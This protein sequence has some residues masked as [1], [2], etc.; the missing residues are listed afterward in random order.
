MITIQRMLSL[1][2]DTIIGLR[3]ELWF[4]KSFEQHKKELEKCLEL[5]DQRA[6]FVAYDSKANLAGVAECALRTDYV[7][8]C[9]TSPVVFL[10]GIFVKPESRRQGVARKL[11]D[12]CAEW[13]H[14]LGAQE[15][16]S[17]VDIENEESI[18][19]H[20]SLGFEEV[21]RVVCF[22]RSC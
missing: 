16:A 2:D 6:F 8:G 7:N 20:R 22:K 4:S 14:V 13:G 12:A 3:S 21:E 9:N 10:E 17:D 1:P 15:F 5:S 18:Q 19:L 11:C